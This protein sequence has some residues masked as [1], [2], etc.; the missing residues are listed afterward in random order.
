MRQA[1]DQVR[2]DL[3]AALEVDGVPLAEG[4]PVAARLEPEALARALVREERGLSAGHLRRPRQA[5][6]V[7]ALSTALGAFVPTLP[8]FFL[9]GPAAIVAAAAVSLAAHFGV[10]VAKSAIVPALRWWAAGGEMTLI[11]AL[12]GAVTFGIGLWAAH[13]LPH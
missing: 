10:G 9:D 3:T 8:F 4:R 6:P 2:A 11:G 5:A 13:L 12:E 7:A 1:P